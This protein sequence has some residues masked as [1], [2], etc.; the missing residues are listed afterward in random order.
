M[1]TAHYLRFVQA[2]ALVATVPACSSADDPKPAT[3]VDPVAETRGT[4]TPATQPA[5]VAEASVADAST[6][7][8]ATDANA[9]DSGT[10]ARIPHTS[11]PLVPPELPEGFA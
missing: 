1:K 6:D 4:E 10:D 11:R 9:T 7:A 3:K 2:L 8:N 5:A